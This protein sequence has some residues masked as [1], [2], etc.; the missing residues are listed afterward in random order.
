MEK[1]KKKNYEVNFDMRWSY[2]VKV[3]AT[4]VV[5]AKKI[6]FARFKKKLARKDFSISVEK[7][8]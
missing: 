5:E 4:S 7:L 2:D 6:A 8:D 3:K 1:A